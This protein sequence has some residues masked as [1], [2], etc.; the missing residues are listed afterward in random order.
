MTPLMRHRT[1]QPPDTEKDREERNMGPE[2]QAE[3]ITRRASFN[4][5]ENAQWVKRLHIK[6]NK[7]LER[8]GGSV[9]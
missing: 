3:A 1:G 4:A 6:E 5:I 8:L 9:S 7:G 2:E